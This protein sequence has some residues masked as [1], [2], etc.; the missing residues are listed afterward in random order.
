MNSDRKLRLED[1]E[2]RLLMAVT[3][4]DNGTTITVNETGPAFNDALV[5]S[6]DD[7]GTLTIRGTNGTK[8]N[9]TANG[10]VQI[11]VDDRTYN[12]TVNL[13][14]GKDNVLLVDLGSEEGELN[15][16]TVRTGI[17][18]D[19]VRLVNIEAEGNLLI[20]TGNNADAFADDVVLDD[21]A[22]ERTTTIFLGG[23]SDRLTLIDID[24][25]GDVRLDGENGNDRIFATEDAFEELDEADEDGRL[26]LQRFEAFVEIDD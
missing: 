8:V 14:K 7:D 19:R 15:N 10:S 22:V 6:E 20:D 17:G 4:V 18:S 24:L 13:N 3:V 25:E 2:D 23:G 5:I 26:R 21:V 9:G 12:L 11:D 16:L 1:L